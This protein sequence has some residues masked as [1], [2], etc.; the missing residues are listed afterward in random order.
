MTVGW[1]K[2]ARDHW[3]TQSQNR[4]LVNRFLAAWGAA[5]LHMFVGCTEGAADL[6]TFVRQVLIEERDEAM[7]EI[8]HQIGEVHEIFQVLTSSAAGTFHASERLPHGF[9]LCSCGTDS[10]QI[11][12]SS[13]L[14]CR[15]AWGTV[16]SP[17]SRCLS[18][19][20]SHLHRTVFNHPQDL[21]TLVN[22]QGG[23]VDDIAD[24]I[25]RTADRTRDAGV[26]LVKAERS[27]R[28]S[29]NRQC[30][31]FIIAGIVLVVLFLVLVS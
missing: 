14:A 7:Q 23:M 8:S 12:A 20:F 25:E 2:E 9:A 18:D 29:R 21:A 16:K 28:G 26:Q 19:L 30:I 6:N 27:Q 4:F 24:H 13:L 15:S 1:P 17:P 3:R 22:D 10:R 31:L 5:C 11:F